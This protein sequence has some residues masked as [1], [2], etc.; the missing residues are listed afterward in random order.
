MPETAFWFSTGFTFSFLVNKVIV[1]SSFQNTRIS[2]FPIL[3]DQGE[4]RGGRG[5]Y[6]AE[7]SIGPLNS[8]LLVTHFN[9]SPGH[10]DS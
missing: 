3:G 1:H 7:L 2:G 4:D 9:P 6:W 5:K 10:I 8:L